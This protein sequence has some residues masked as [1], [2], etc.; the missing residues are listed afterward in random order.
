MLE[1]CCFC[2]V[3]VIYLFAFFLVQRTHTPP[4]SCFGH[5]MGSG[6]DV[7]GVTAGHCKIQLC[8]TKGEAKVFAT[9]EYFCK[10]CKN[11][12]QCLEHLALFSL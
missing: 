2:F 8:I 7:T 11:E 9:K 10:Q 1:I 3:L 5:I 6:Y 12:I 4:E